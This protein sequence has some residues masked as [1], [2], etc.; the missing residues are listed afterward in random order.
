MKKTYGLIILILLNITI[1]FL[2]GQIF[3]NESFEPMIKV[4]IAL[5][6][7]I[8]TL[9]I[10]GKS[11]KILCKRVKNSLPEKKKRAALARLRRKKHITNLL[12]SILCVVMVLVNYYYFKANEMLNA[13]TFA[14]EPTEL[15]YYVYV[16]D[17]S[18]ITSLSDPSIINIGFDEI[19]QNSGF[20]LLQANLEHQQQRVC[21]ADFMPM[22]ISPTSDIYQKLLNEEVEV[23]II[24]DN[25]LKSLKSIYPNF[26]DETRL[27]KEISIPTGVKS[28]NVNVSKEPFN[29]LIMGVDIRESEGDIYSKTRTD[30]LMV[31]S[32]NPQ[33]M[34]ASL[35]SIPRDSYVPIA[36]YDDSHYDKITHAG[37]EGVGCTIETVENLLDIDINYYAKFNF[38]A[39]VNLV[40]ALGGIDVDVKFSFSEQDSNDQKD[41]IYLEAG[42][43]I[44]DGQQALAYA[45]HRKTQNDHV[46]NVSQQQVLKAI[47]AKL[48]SFDTVTKIDD[49][50]KVM[51]KNMTTNF[52]RD[53]LISLV[54]LIPKLKDLQISNMVIDGIDEETYVPLYDQYL[55]ITQLDDTSVQKARQTILDLMAR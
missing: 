17:D 54:G 37:M 41:A 6:V 12:L 11:L 2:T 21:Y 35:I 43:Q 20:S 38:N 33:T 19:E 5:G 50:F 8:V 14:M 32:F 46:R 13:I 26:E 10:D 29:V 51:Q 30:T 42:Q 18:D 16:V 31:A 1:I 45:R 48:A 53:E 3:Y 28:K 39:L 36:G 40:D 44:L 34:E 47:L 23:I 24:G 9:M 22:F 49:L 52:N 15:N 27:I 25:V 55:W 4:A 7:L